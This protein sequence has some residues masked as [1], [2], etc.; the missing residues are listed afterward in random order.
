MQ[1]LAHHAVPRA[2]RCG[3]HV[4]I[5]AALNNRD[6]DQA[7]E[8]RRHTGKHTGNEFGG[9]GPLSRYGVMAHIT[10]F[11]VA[12]GGHLKHGADE[13]GQFGLRGDPDQRETGWLA[14]S[15]RSASGLQSR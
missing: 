5:E 14:M 13:L 15:A 9:R 3:G 1:V 12:P 7:L 2:R 10:R 8:P 11:G 6:H 4:T